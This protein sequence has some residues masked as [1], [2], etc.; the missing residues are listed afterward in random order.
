MTLWLECIW[1]PGK[2]AAAQKYH[3]VLKIYSFQ[4]LES[5]AEN[6]R[7]FFLLILRC[8]IISYTKALYLFW[9]R[10]IHKSG[11]RS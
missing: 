9:P 6:M 4:E 10:R 11:N 1:R 2:F 7:S 3:T 5:K 8:Q